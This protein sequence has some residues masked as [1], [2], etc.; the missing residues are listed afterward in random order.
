MPHQ[1]QRLI[2]MNMESLSTFIGAGAAAMDVEEATTPKAADPETAAAD[3]A[4]SANGGTPSKDGDGKEEVRWF[5]RVHKPSVA[6]IHGHEVHPVNVGNPANPSPV[7]D[8]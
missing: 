7:N 4:R 2:Y 1:G 5:Q 6:C 3:G 8:S